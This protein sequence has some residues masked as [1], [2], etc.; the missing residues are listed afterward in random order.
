MKIEKPGVGR[1]LLGPAKNNTIRTKGEPQSN[2]LLSQSHSVDQITSSMDVALPNQDFSGNIK[3]IY[4]Q[5]ETMI[6]RG[7]TLVTGN[8]G[9]MTKAYV[10]NVCGKECGQKISINDHIVTNYLEGISL[11]CNLC[12]NTF[13]SRDSLNYPKKSHINKC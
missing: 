10:C 13:R 7:D 8:H 12:E 9:R 6:G 1:P 3:D 11:P 2:P 5:I 4:E